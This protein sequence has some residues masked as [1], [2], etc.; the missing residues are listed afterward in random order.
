MLEVT[1]NSAGTV[2]RKDHHG[3]EYGVFYTEIDVMRDVQS[4]WSRPVHLAISVIV[5]HDRK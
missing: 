5:F 2:Y 3:T 1:V 4:L